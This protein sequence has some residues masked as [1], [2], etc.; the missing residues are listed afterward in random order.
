MT[1]LCQVY[2]LD[3]L[4]PSA[5]QR[6]TDVNFSNDA[7][8]DKKGQTLLVSRSSPSQPPQVYLADG[9]GKRLTWVE[10]N[11]LTRRILMRL[12]LP[13]TGC[14]HS[15]RSGRRTAHHSTGR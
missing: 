6:L 10:E 2:S 11:A 7:S 13:H 1:N 5:P 14:R 8:M 4:N 12:I 3:Y 15:G 9:N